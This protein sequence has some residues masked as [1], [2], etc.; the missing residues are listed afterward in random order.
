MEYCAERRFCGQNNQ[1]L[2]IG[3]CFWYK[4]ALISGDRPVSIGL[5]ALEIYEDIRKQEKFP[6]RGEAKHV[7]SMS[8]YR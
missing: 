1:I 7:Q 8:G 5:T 4:V 3:G 6:L 2:A